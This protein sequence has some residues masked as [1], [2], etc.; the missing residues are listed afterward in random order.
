MNYLFLSNLDSD[1]SKTFRENA[2]GISR[3]RCFPQHHLRPTKLSTVSGSVAAVQE[4]SDS[5]VP[6]MHFGMQNIKRLGPDGLLASDLQTLVTQVDQ[7]IDESFGELLESVETDNANF[8]TFSL[9]LEF[10]VADA[11]I[12]AEARFGPH[13]PDPE[14]DRYFTALA[15]HLHRLGVGPEVVVPVCFKKSAWAIVSMMGILKAGGAFVPLDAAHPPA[16]LLEI[17]GQVGAR[18][19]LTSKEAPGRYYAL[20]S[21]L[22]TNGKAMRMSNQTR[23]IHFASYT[24]DACII[25]ILG[26]MYYGGCICIPSEEVRMGNLAQAITGMRAN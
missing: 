14:L 20:L 8:E 19:V 23:I 17:I 7:E 15:N 2:I 4:Y 11:G 6:H 12:M 26:A 25:E 3:A 22:S 10:R 5:L 16:R 9:T 13:V 1:V 21:S 24:F 18:L